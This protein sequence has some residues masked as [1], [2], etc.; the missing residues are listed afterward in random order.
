MATAVIEPAV[1]IPRVRVRRGLG[2]HHAVAVETAVL[3]GVFIVGY[4][5]VGHRVVVS[6]HVVIGDA[7]SRLAH[8]YYAWHND[9]PKLAAIGF[10]WPPVQTVAYLPLGIVKPIATSL[11]A[12]PV[13]QR[14]L[15]GGDPRGA[16]PR[17]R[18]AGP[19]PDSAHA[20]ARRPSA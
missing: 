15:R 3:M 8:A 4:T 20:A 19:A 5:L 17:P 14:V 6:Q 13:V 12:M 7:L 1:P 9:P 2:A 11:T 16:Q 18:A 10:A